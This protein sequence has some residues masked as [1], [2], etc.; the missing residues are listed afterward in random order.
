MLI[1]QQ[2]TMGN[3]S[4]T[5]ARRVSTNTMN[6]PPEY[7]LIAQLSQTK[8][9]SQLL[10]T[11]QDKGLQIVQIKDKNG[12]IYP[13]PT[14]FLEKTD[15]SKIPEYEITY[16][17]SDG[18]T[19]SFSVDGKVNYKEAVLLAIE[20]LPVASEQ[21]EQATK[22]VN[23]NEYDKL[24]GW[25]KQNNLYDNFMGLLQQQLQRMSGGVDALSSGD[26]QMAYVQGN[27]IQEKTQK[28]TA[29][30][31]DDAKRNVKDV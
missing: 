3:S 2:T 15:F 27:I 30:A 9:N 17:T 5:S 28:T 1:F 24:Y 12:I 14:N 6:P 19:Q 4:E 26:Q 21:K 10:I 18:K 16:K 29:D 23:N 11:L 13:P 8:S 7:Q 25:L 20:N 22:W 31:I